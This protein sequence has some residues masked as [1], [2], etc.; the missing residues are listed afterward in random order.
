MTNPYYN[1]TSAPP[2]QTRGSSSTMRSEFTLIGAG[3]DALVTALALKGNVAS[4]TWTGTHTFPST[5]YGVTATAGSNNL[6]LSTT[7]Y[8]DRA[9]SVM[10][11][12]NLPSVSGKNTTW[13][14]TPNASGTGVQWTQSFGAGGTAITGNTT[15]T[16]S[17][18]SAMTVTPTGWGLGVALPDATTCT[19]GVGLFSIYNAGDY[20]YS[21]YNTSGTKLGFIYPR[22]TVY[23][24]LSDNSTAAGSW[25]CAGVG[26][27]GIT[28]QYTNNTLTNSG[29]I[30]QIL[31][32]DS[33]RA[34][35]LF[36]GT[37]VYGQMYDKSTNAWGTPV[38]IRTGAGNSLYAAVLSAAAQIAVVSC[39]STTGI[40]VVT[41]TLSGAV[42][43]TLNSGT[44]ATAVLASN[45]S[46]LSPDF[47]AFGTGFAFGY[48]RSGSVIGVRGVS[49]SGTT[50]TIGAESAL[51]PASGSAPLLLVSGSTLRTISYGTTQ[52]ACKPFTIS[53]SAL[54][55]GTESV[56]T[57][58]AT[59]PLRAFL[60]GNGNIVASYVNTTPQVTIFKLTGTVEASSTVQ[61]SSTV[62]PTALATTEQTIISASKTTF[63]SGLTGNWAINTI[64]D[65][66][67]TASAG[68]QITGTVSGSISTVCSVPTSANSARYVISSNTEIAQVVADCSGASPSLTATYSYGNLTSGT[69][70][71]PQS[72]SIRG[73]RN[74]LTLTSNSNTIGYSSTASAMM[75][76][77]GGGGF[78]VPQFP[79]QVNNSSVVDPSAN[80]LVWTQPCIAT[81]ATIYRIEAIL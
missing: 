18:A 56:V 55:A 80:N 34:F 7:E 17:S 53:G 2:A 27:L 70:A 48:T 59:A 81:A 43:M 23:I 39:D 60:N 37:T 63:F 11:S 69:Y 35:I 61:L 10:P 3:F 64:T 5:T 4:Q 9:I 46:T 31:T 66:A 74:G 8:V 14:L 42:G 58:T 24:G 30:Q 12:G 71:Y 36:G 51:T 49:I 13:N 57:T 40:E 25:V 68:T 78:L 75:M 29:A 77:N 41:I 32:V 1:P 50:P 47:V 19:K 21:I 52:L 6:L 65:T 44:K 73:V 72:T 38:T 15:L 45:I 28:A 33:T 16:V 76:T 67:G 22:S 54:S 79:V 20:D 26:K 62:T